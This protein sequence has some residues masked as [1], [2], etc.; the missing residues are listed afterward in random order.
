MINLVCFATQNKGGMWKELTKCL[1]DV[2]INVWSED[3]T[4]RDKS[5]DFNSFL[6]H[7]FF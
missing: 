3:L 7:L 1:V 6:M 4:R 2:T 5:D